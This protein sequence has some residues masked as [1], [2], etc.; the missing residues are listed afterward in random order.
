MQRQKILLLGVL[1]IFI[2]SLAFS[3]HAQEEDD[4]IY[5]NFRIGY[6]MVDTS[7]ADCK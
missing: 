4:T 6:R 5:G 7:G 3:L 1:F 2:F